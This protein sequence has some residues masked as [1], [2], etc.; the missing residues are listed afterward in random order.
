MARG[1]HDQPNQDLIIEGSKKIHPSKR[2]QGQ[3]YPMMVV[4]EL[5]QQNKGQ[6][7]KIYATTQFISIFISDF[8]N[9]TTLNVAN[10]NVSES[11]SGLKGAGQNYFKDPLKPDGDTCR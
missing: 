2:V 5:D 4:E 10:G 11:S 6:F 3:D 8:R 7:Y 1:Q 9:P